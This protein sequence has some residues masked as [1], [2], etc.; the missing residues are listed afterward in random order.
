MEENTFYSQTIDFITKSSKQFGFAKLLPHFE[1]TVYWTQ[2]LDPTADKAQLISAFSHDADRVT[3]PNKKD[4]DKRT[5][6]DDDALKQ[7]QVRGAEIMKNFLIDIK[8]PK[9]LYEEVYRLIAKHEVGGDK[10]QN[11]LMD[12]DSL[13]FLEKNVD[14]FLDKVQ[15]R[16]KKQV[17]EKFDWMYNRISSRKAKKWQSPCIEMQ[18]QN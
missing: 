17:R 1:R 9:R 18:Y 2:Q 13:S 14:L 4:P 11:I 10:K 16:G 6:Q 15:E 5:Y 8:A 7:H 3:Q 12:A